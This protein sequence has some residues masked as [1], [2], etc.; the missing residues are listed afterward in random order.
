LHL[1]GA[2]GFLMIGRTTTT[3]ESAPLT[4]ADDFSH[5]SVDIAVD[6]GISGQYVTRVLDRTALFRGYNI[7]CRQKSGTHRATLCFGT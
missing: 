5:E 6:F 1:S 2:H 7:Q 3:A 4:A